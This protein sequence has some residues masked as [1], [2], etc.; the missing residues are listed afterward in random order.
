MIIKPLRDPQASP[1]ALRSHPE[2]EH[3][4]SALETLKLKRQ[5]TR[6]MKFDRALFYL[7]VQ[8]RVAELLEHRS[9][10]GVTTQL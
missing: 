9:K 6:T 10:G 7:A 2:S 4:R 5:R 1:L 3:P 8:E